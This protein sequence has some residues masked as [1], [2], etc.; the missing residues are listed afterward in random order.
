M[1]FLDEGQD[2][3][4]VDDEPNARGAGFGGPQRRRQQYLVRR[5]IGGRRRRLGFTD[6]DRDRV[7]GLPRGT[8]RP[9]AAQLRRGR[10]DDHAA[11]EQS[12]RTSSTCSMASS[13]SSSSLDAQQEV[14]RQRDTSQT[15]LDRANDIGAAGPDARRPER[16]HPDPDLAAGRSQLDRP[17]RHARQPPERRPAPRSPRSATR[18]APSMRATSSGPRSASP[19]SRRSSTT[20]ASTRRT[21]PNGKFMPAN[22]TDYLNQ[23]TL[24]TKLNVLTGQTVDHRGRPWP[25]AR[26]RPRSGTRR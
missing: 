21:L 6:P 5:L 24:V 13:G 20:R 4:V 14:L 22:A 2:D 12:G 11:V 16:R 9:G 8:L 19:R 25:A 10:R 26:L 3:L 17:E 1:A 23:T 7:P 15:L 18:W